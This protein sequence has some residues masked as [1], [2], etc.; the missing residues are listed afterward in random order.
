M[1]TEFKSREQIEEEKMIEFKER[2]VKT[3]S[4]KETD[5]AMRLF[6]GEIKGNDR[7][8]ISNRLIDVKFKLKKVYKDLD[9]IYNYL[10]AMNSI[11]ALPKNEEEELLGYID[12]Y[13]KYINTCGEALVDVILPEIDK[14]F[15]DDEIIQLIS[16]NHE[17]VKKIKEWYSKKE[18]EITS[19]STIYIVHHAE[20]RW[21]KG[22]S[23]DF[24]DCPS[25]EMPLFNCVS[26]YMIGEIR[27]VPKF[28]NEML[29]F[30]ENLF[31][32]SMIYTSTGER[33]IKIMPVREI[34]RKFKGDFVRKLKA[35]KEIDLGKEYRV[36][37]FNN[38]S[39]A[40][41]S[42]EGEILHQ[43]YIK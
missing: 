6:F 15:S 27:K 30:Q 32:E 10:N 19:L 9:V 4:E 16:G 38:G 31:G 26:D 17:E 35:N 33:V 21:R 43:L 36:K 40:I 25:W 24:V 14:H 5:R 28:H 37:N 13:K 39:Y 7:L 1:I 8:F 42:D 29:E 22:R 20:Y 41:V 2:Y 11:E 3:F 12:E 18:E 34:I 23:K